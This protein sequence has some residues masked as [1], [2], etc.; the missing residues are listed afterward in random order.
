MRH[1]MEPYRKRRH[2]WWGTKVSEE[3]H[4]PPGRDHRARHPPPLATSTTACRARR[5]TGG[6]TGR[7]PG[8]RSTTCTWPARWRSPGATASSRSATTC[9]SGCS[10]PTCWPRRPPRVEEADLELVRRAARSHGVATVRC[11]ADYYRTPPG[12][13]E[14]GRRRVVEEGELEPVR[15]QGWN[16]PAYLHRDARLPRRVDARAL[17]SP[18]DPVCWLRERTEKLFDFHYRIEIYTPAAQRQFGTRPP[19]PARRGRSSAASTSRPTVSPGGCVVKAAY[20][21]RNAPVETAE[22]L[23]GRAAPAAGGVGDGQLRSSC[24]ATW[25]RCSV[26]EQRLHPVGA[27]RRRRAWPGPGSPSRAAACRCGPS[28][29]RSEYDGAQILDRRLLRHQYAR[30]PP[31]PADCPTIRWS[32]KG[33]IGITTT[34]RSWASACMVVEWPRCPMTRDIDGISSAWGTKRYRPWLAAG[35]QRTRVDDRVPW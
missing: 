12:T 17:L 9:P 6:G 8:A 24:G 25:R 27:V 15:I 28:A 26:S 21:E 30:R 34:G 29:S 18:F 16:R 5:T 33:C 19:V 23:V 3:L 11:L 32:S 2:K 35:A 20:A 22:E 1:R 10:P 13:G 14:A 31:A 4:Q 7:R